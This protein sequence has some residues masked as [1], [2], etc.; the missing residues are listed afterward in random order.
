MVKDYFEQEYQQLIREWKC[1]RTE[2]EQWE[3]RRRMARLERTAAAVYGTQ[4]SDDLH[5]RYVGQLMR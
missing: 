5:T 3:I 1:C 2:D 4:Y